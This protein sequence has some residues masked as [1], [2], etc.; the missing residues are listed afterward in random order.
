MKKILFILVLVF[1]F[2]GINAGINHIKEQHAMY[3]LQQINEQMTEA[4]TMYLQAHPDG[5]C[6]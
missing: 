5:V 4:C 1:T 2:T 3:E 6:D